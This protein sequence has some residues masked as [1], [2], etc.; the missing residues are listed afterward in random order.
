MCDIIHPYTFMSNWRDSSIQ[1]LSHPH[2]RI[3]IV[4]SLSLSLPLSFKVMVAAMVLEATTVYMLTTVY[5]KSPG[6][7][8]TVQ[9]RSTAGEFPEQ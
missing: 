3:C 4:F 9:T 7:A 5:A 2:V 6:L 1:P 8:N